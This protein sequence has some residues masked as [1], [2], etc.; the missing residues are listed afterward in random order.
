LPQIG[1]YVEFPDG[2]VDKLTSIEVDISTTNRLPRFGHEV[3]GLKFYR[4]IPHVEQGHS[5]A[6]ATIKALEDSGY[7]VAV[8][9]H[10]HGLF[11][12]DTK[13]N[14]VV[15]GIQR[16]AREAF[17][18]GSEWVSVIIASAPPE[19]KRNPRITKPGISL[20]HEETE[21]VR[22]LINGAVMGAWEKFASLPLETRQELFNKFDIEATVPS[23]LRQY[24]TRNE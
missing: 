23:G 18:Q 2:F 14:N 15:D 13:F 12:L 8:A 4:A 20:T 1:D 9:Q 16:G 24:V 17:D 11:Q 19:R 6:F 21:A 22:D 7:Q 5:P 3:A 10:L